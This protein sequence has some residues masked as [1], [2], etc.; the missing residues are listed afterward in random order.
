[1][2]DNR[3]PPT[4]E[5]RKETGTQKTLPKATGADAAE[6][7]WLKTPSFVRFK[8]KREAAEK[9]PPFSSGILVVSFK[10]CLM[11]A[12]S[13]AHLML[14]SH[15]IELPPERPNRLSPGRLAHLDSS[16]QY[17]SRELR[18]VSSAT[19][20]TS[21][22]ADL[23]INCYEFSYNL[24]AAVSKEQFAYNRAS[25]ASGD[26][27]PRNKQKTSGARALRSAEKQRDTPR[28]KESS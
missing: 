4:R 22:P 11:K 13:T 8:Q 2:S 16:M 20:T 6:G 7:V 19:E 14:F 3:F 17:G 28:K 12:H 26:D 18:T 15:K 21:A 5:R 1:M 25:N 10:L 24:G 27:L 23:W 9:V